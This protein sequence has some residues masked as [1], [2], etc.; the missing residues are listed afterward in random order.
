MAAP[1]VHDCALAPHVYWALRDDQ[2]Y[3]EYVAAGS[4]PPNTVEVLSRNE[5]EDGLITEVKRV[6]TLK[7]PIPYSMRSMLG[8]KDGFAF[9]ITEVWHR[10][11]YDAANPMTFTIQ[12]A[13]MANKI[14][15][16]GSQWVEPRD[17]GCRLFFELN[18][19]CRVK[20][21]GSLIS[22]G[23]ASGTIASYAQLP[24]RALEYVTLRR[25]GSEASEA[26]QRASSRL[27]G[28]AGRHTGASTRATDDEGVDEPTE[29]ATAAAA[30]AAA[31]AAQLAVAQGERAR[32]RWRMALMGVRFNRNLRFHASESHRQ[33]DV[34]IDEPR[35]EG[36][37]PKKHTT[38]RVRSRVNTAP[39]PHDA[40]VEVRKRFSEFVA[41]REALLAFLPG[42][43][44]PPLPERHVS[45]RFTPAVVELRRATLE[46][47]LQGV[48]DHGVAATSDELASF[49]SWS[50]PTRAP[51]FSRA[52]QLTQTPAAPQRVALER[53]WALRRARSAGSF[54]G[55]GGAGPPSAHDDFAS[56]GRLSRR[57][58]SSTADGSEAVML[59]AQSSRLSRFASG[60][61]AQLEVDGAYFTPTD[62]LSRAGSLSRVGSLSR[63]GS[64]SRVGSLRTPASFSDALASAI[65]KAADEAA[66]VVQAR[67]RSRN[68]SSCRSSRLT[69]GD[70]DGDRRLDATQRTPSG[71]G[72]VPRQ[73][74]PSP[75]STQRAP[76]IPPPVSAFEAAAATAER[77]SA[78]ADAISG[79]TSRGAVN[80]SGSGSGSS[81]ANIHRDGGGID[82]AIRPALGPA[83]G[84]GRGAGTPASANGSAVG[85]VAS[86]GTEMAAATLVLQKLED[87]EARLRSIEAAQRRQWLWDRVFGCSFAR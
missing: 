30:A 82:P 24:E 17:S 69:E 79:G 2:R 14:E 3:S 51:L 74:S 42:L 11:R 65:L 54:A 29:N 1:I 83:L 37:G 64:L 25:A 40:W 15:V 33:C 26:F 60:L 36:F 7:N 34:A 67:A 5:T 86:A 73:G 80:G 22:K 66:T 71:Y 81:R 46:A 77:L 39:A 57:T 85:A 43:E 61:S 48:A 8:C 13:V 20:G 49:V 44:L 41:L 18:V 55:G 10:D 56:P 76:P 59:S 32:L 53:V 12:P 52:Q 78:R 4:D 38:Y 62:G 72:A 84:P 28:G 31:E 70:D 87:L 19:S 16:S 45:H 35:T 23:I 9:T 47:F 68:A 27:T 6:A 63:A 50:E 58:S 21:V 75:L